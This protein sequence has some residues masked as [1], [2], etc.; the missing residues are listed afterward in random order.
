MSITARL[1]C[2]GIL[3]GPT[4]L[5]L[6]LLVP[7]SPQTAALHLATTTGLA[8]IVGR[9]LRLLLQVPLAPA[10]AGRHRI[11]PR[12]PGAAVVLGSM[13]VALVLVG[14]YLAVEGGWV[15]ALAGWLTGGT[16]LFSAVNYRR[17]A[18]WEGYLTIV[19]GELIVKTPHSSYKI[20]L[21]H[22]QLYRRRRDGSVLVVSQDRELEALILP[23]RARGR[24]W[25]DGAEALVNAL[26]QW[27]PVV[28]VESLLAI[29]PA[30]GS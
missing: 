24:Y 18:L 15:H 12:Y 28:E 3:W 8:F 11:V 23:R 16:S 1:F 26:A 30:E 6:A 20:P 7:P 5:M 27:S 25:V 9:I 19:G 21:S 17:M 13:G 2:F 10:S 22:A 14:S 4:L 29:A